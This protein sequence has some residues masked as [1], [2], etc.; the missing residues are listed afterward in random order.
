LTHGK[1]WVFGGK[2]RKG[3]VTKSM[4]VKEQVGG[5][6]EKLLGKKQNSPG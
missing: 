1:G 2:T 5:S 6:K 4:G 3:Y